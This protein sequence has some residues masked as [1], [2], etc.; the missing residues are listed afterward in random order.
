MGASRD[1]TGMHGVAYNAQIYVGNTNNNDSFL[2]GPKPDPRYFKAV[3]DALADAGVRD[4]QQ[5]GQSAA[6]C[7]LSHPGRSAR[8]L[9]PALESGHLARRGGGRLAPWRDQRVQCRQQRLPERQRALGAAVLSAGSGRPLA[10]SLGLDQSNQQKYNQCGIAKYWCITTPGAKIDSTIRAAVMRSSPAPRW[11]RRTP[12]A[13]W[14][15]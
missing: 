2:F 3:Y 7:Q 14:R 8:R 1:G 11:P 9:R 4:Q 5:L 10:G 13:P 6:G 15:W 12:P